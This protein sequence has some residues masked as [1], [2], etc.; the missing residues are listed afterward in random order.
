MKG[1]TGKDLAAE[2]DRQ[3]PGIACYLG[4]TG[5]MAL[6][7][8]T[9]TFKETLPREAAEYLVRAWSALEAVPGDAGA[10][11]GLLR[12]ALCKLRDEWQER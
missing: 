9:E 10:E 12:D 1:K 4:L 3:L 5:A 11:K 8:F 7:R 2:I 6:R